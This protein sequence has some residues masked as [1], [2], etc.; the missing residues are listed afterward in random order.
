MQINRGKQQIVWI[1][2]NCGKLLKKWEHQTTLPI[3]WETC[4]QVK[5]QQLE[6]EMEQ[7]RGSK[8]EKE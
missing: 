5:K 1:I 3:S 8:L 2:A 7:R 4:M 6:P